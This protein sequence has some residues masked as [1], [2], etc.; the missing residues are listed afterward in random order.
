MK[1]IGN[2]DVGRLIPVLSVCVC[3]ST[4]QYA[5]SAFQ[6]CYHNWSGA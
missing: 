5:S 3:D 6:H 1:G 4:N 2:T